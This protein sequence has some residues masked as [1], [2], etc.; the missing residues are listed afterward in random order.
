M[1]STQ[2]SKKYFDGLSLEQ[3]GEH[4]SIKANPLK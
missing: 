2:S 1:N 3:K 4:H